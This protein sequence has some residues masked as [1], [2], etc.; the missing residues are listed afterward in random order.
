MLETFAAPG[1]FH[2]G[3]LHGHSTNSD[4]DLT[5]ARHCAFYEAAG[6]DFVCLSDHFRDAYG[7]P[8]TDTVLFRNAD[9]TTI[10]GSELHAGALA[11][12]EI[13]HFLGVGLPSDFAP[14]GDDETGPNLAKRALDAGAFVAL[15][16]P[17]WYGLTLEDALT[18]PEGIHAVEVFNSICAST[19]RGEG[20]SLLDEMLMAGRK[21]GAIAVDD[22][23]RYQRDALR[24]WVQV[25]ATAQTPEALLDALKAGHYYASTGAEVHHVERVGDSLHVECSPAASVWLLGH[26]AKSASVFGE[27]ITRARLPLERFEGGF[28]RL[29]IRAVDGT[30][31]WTNS[32]WLD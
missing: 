5:P 1:R 11:N 22:V 12:G 20:S 3:N 29:V 16:H 8:V 31:A 4:G 32:L 9:F 26:G 18:M 7:F 25:K 19:G 28:A 30:R 24:G 23:H 21:V 15:A 17:E 10:L 6:Y 14:T 2:K 27:E 13:W